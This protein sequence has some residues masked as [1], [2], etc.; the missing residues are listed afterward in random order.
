MAKY[1]MMKGDG[2]LLGED[3]SV[4]A[5]IKKYLGSS[6]RVVEMDNNVNERHIKDLHCGSFVY[7]SII[8]SGGDPMKFHEWSHKR[9]GSNW[10]HNHERE[11]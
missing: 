1:K 5:L 7:E 3:D 8:E 11:I 9:V 4:T 6:Y 2:V 10:E